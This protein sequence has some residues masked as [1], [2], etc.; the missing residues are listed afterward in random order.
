MNP[1]YFFN[2]EDI[3]EKINAIVNKLT[4][5]KNPNLITMRMQ[6]N[7]ARY[8]LNKSNL[9]NYYLIIWI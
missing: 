5:K 9:I 1:E 2:A 8:Y 6:L 7:F 3:N 4:D